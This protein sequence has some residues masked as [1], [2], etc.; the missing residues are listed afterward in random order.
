M[1]D[2]VTEVA[3]R[4]AKSRIEIG[5]SRPKF[6]AEGSTPSNRSRRTSPSTTSSIHVKER[7]CSPLPSMGSGLP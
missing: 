6:T 3:Y 4:L 5:S 2:D 7:T 1:G